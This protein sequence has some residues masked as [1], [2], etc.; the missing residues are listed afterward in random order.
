MIPI[1]SEKEIR[2]MREAC[3]IAA[4]VLDGLCQ[5]AQ[6]GVSTWDLDQAAKDLMEKFSSRSACY[7][8]KQGSLRY[9][10]YICASVNDEIIHGIGSKERI[11]KDGD[12]IS[13][14]VSVVYQGF[15][16]DNTRTVAIGQVDSRVKD[17]LTSTEKALELGIA[18]ACE[19]NRVGDISNA[20]QTYIESKG[21]GIIKEFTGH[22]V[23]KKLHE[24]P[25]VPNYG[26]RGTGAILRS[27]M[28]L[29]IEPMV[30]MG[31]PE[32]KFG[33]DK[34]TVLTADGKP[35]SHAEHTVLIT[36]GKPEILTKF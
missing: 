9:P 32:I 15:I 26:K 14:D 23:G 7:K 31:S 13:M 25:E 16:G 12:I 5:I 22:G 18:Q 35:S 24:P 20:I 10:S 19:G 6:V 3:V 21:Y 29:A 36:D 34:W 28:T 30:S 2:I 8:Y 1:K 33:S 27:G 17:L 4:K 11:L